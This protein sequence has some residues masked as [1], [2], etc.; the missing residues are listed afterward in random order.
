MYVTPARKITNIHIVDFH[1]G[2]LD[3]KHQ[4]YFGC[5]FMVMIATQQNAK[6]PEA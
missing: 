2:E 3:Y 6:L 5:T 1:P 4:N